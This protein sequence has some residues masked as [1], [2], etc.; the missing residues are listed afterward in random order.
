MAHQPS[1]NA[2]QLAPWAQK[3]LGLI[4]RLGH[5]VILSTIATSC[6]VLGARAVGSLQGLELG[7]Y[8]QMMRLRPALEPDDRIL[9]VGIDETDI[10]VR[11]EWPIEDK[12]LAELLQILMAAEPRAIG[13][14]FFRDV[15]IGEGQASLLS[16]IQT[17]DLIFP[18]CRISG[19][20]TPG[21]P[22]PPGTPDFQVGFADLVVDPGGIL[23]RMVLLTLPPEEPSS[24]DLHLCSDPTVQL[25]SLSFQLA[26]RYLA[27]EGINPEITPDQEF[28][29]QDTVLE[30]IG[31]EIGGYRNVDAGGYQLLLNFRAAEAAVPQVSLSEV[32]SGQVS[33]EQIRDRIVLIGATTPEANDDFYTPYSGGLRDSQKMPGVIVHAQAV[34]QIFGAVLDDRPLLWSWSSVGEGVWIIAWGLGGALFAWYARRPVTFT[35]GAAVLLGG[36]YGGCYFLLLQGGWIPLIPAALALALAAGSVV[37]LDR[38]NKSDYG[39]AVYK[40]MK[41]LLRLEIEIDQTSVGKQVT[42]ITETEYFASLQQQ[43]QQLRNR[44]KQQSASGSSRVPK[45]K[46]QSPKSETVADLDDYFDNLKQE[47]RRLK[48]TNSSQEDTPLDDKNPDPHEDS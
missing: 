34:S 26:L 28:K 39:Q 4:G 16:L 19:P 42:E 35:S 37:L 24:T 47:A 8:D 18:V 3:C 23:R 17:S 5:P 9:V 10:Q 41:S 13:L 1:S 46:V 36:L 22:P 33:P 15:P 43:A 7:T 25:P 2:K 6:I 44:G 32:L 40:Q 45:K 30:R 31:P 11:R 29:L 48:E 38:F 20:D 21:V 12:T 14:D 27:E